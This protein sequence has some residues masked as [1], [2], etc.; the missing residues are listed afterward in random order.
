VSSSC[1]ECGR[2]VAEDARF[3]P[4]CGSALDSSDDVTRA[5]PSG[6]P[7]AATIAPALTP[8]RPLSR[9]ASSPSAASN[10]SWLSTPDVAHGRFPPGTIL[11]DR[12]RIVGRLGKGGMGEVYRADDLKLGQPVALKFLPA[13]VEADPVRLAQFHNEVRL[14]RQISH[15]NICRMYDIGEADG[16]PFMTME[17]VDGEDL[18]SLLRRIGR[19]PEDKALELAHQLCAG[20]AAAHERGVL[21]RDLKPANVMIDGSGQVR[22]TDFGLAAIEGAADISHAGTPAYMAPELLAGKDPSVQSDIFALGLVLYEIF[23][24]RRAYT[25]QTIRDLIRQQ[26]E[27]SITQPRAIVKDLDPGIERAIT[28]AL[29]RDPADRPASVQAVAASLPGGDPLAAALAAGETPSPE[30]VAAAG[31]RAAATRTH[32]LLASAAVVALLVVTAAASLQY[33]TL[34]RIDLSK[35]PAVLVD[36]AHQVIEAVGFGKPS[37]HTHWH[38]DTD[39]DLERE[40]VDH[41]DLLNGN[42]V[43]SRPGP[44]RFWWRS[45]PRELLPY[46]PTS[47]VTNDDPPWEVSG[48]TL[49]GL[50]A[51]GRLLRFGALQQ[52]VDDSPPTAPPDWSKLFDLAGLDITKF[53]SATPMWLPRGDSDARAAWTGA[54]PDGPANIRVEAAAWRGRPIY[55]EVLMPWARPRRMEEAPVSLGE[56]ILSAAESVFTLLIL[57]VAMFLARHNVRAG[58]GDVTGATRL[59]VVAFAAEMVAWLLTNPHSSSAGREIS[60]LFSQVGEALFSGGVL[61]VMYLAAEP[62]M[63]HYWPDSLLGST[64]LLRGRIIDARVGRDLL[65]GLTAGAVIQLVLWAR[66]P[67]TFALGAQYQ[68]FSVGNPDF[69]SG[70]NYVLALILV[71]AGFQ[72]MFAAMWCILGIVGLKRLLKRM[73]LVGIVAT[74][75][76][77][78]VIGRNLFLDVKGIPWLNLLTAA[79]VVGVIVLLAIRTGLLATAAALLATNVY[80]AMP[81]TLDTSSWFFPQT[82]LALGALTALAAMAGYAMLSGAAESPRRAL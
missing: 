60:R 76:L 69:L 74:V 3:C 29:E 4:A 71:H 49:V 53:Q 48:M 68:S 31:E 64:R 42:V 21:H 67:I 52:Q 62:A 15:K 45:S 82:A 28:R 72:S 77:T 2:P 40:L 41:P 51:Q 1:L 75:L 37:A 43:G 70:L 18:A 34:R 78:L 73:W 6:T 33:R 16:L 38:F 65:I 30:M 11:A 22:I 19:L 35:P 14:A 27:S 46:D 12:Y 56:R 9:P 59:A 54:M 57:L 66:D 36:R 63:R 20:L 26:N 17:Y 80:S 10:P 32:A 79:L 23:T 8:A 39:A 50:D 13:T 5:A 25:A 55:F 81:W 47:L 24:G 58:R 7:D 44:V 61:F